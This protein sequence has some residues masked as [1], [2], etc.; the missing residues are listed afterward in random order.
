M[1]CRPKRHGLKLHRE[2]SDVTLLQV[3]LR[4]LLPKMMDAMK[5]LVDLASRPTLVVLRRKKWMS[6]KL[7][8]IIHFVVGALIV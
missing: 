5:K 4:E 7:L 2:S 8:V 3:S 1:R 6:T